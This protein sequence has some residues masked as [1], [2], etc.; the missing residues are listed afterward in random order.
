MQTTVQQLTT[1][2]ANGL[3]TTAVTPLDLFRLELVVTWGTPYLQHHARFSTVRV[4]N[5]P[6][7]A[8]NTIP[9]PAPIGARQ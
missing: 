8:G 1:S 9:A 4:M 5:P 7:N 2:N 3:V 6:M